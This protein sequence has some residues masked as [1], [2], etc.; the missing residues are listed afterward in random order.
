[1]IGENIVKSNCARG[2]ILKEEPLEVGAIVLSQSDVPPHPH[3]FVLIT[4]A[5]GAIPNARKVDHFEGN[6]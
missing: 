6:I 2:D 4:G 1:L 5:I 3:M